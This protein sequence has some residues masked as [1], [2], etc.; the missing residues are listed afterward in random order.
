MR[1]PRTAA[2]GVGCLISMTAGGLSATLPLILGGRGNAAVYCELNDAFGSWMLQQRL[3]LPEDERKM[4]GAARGWRRHYQCQR[5][6]H[7]VVVT[8][9]AG[10]PGRIAAHSPEICYA[11]RDY[12]SMTTART[13][14]VD[15]VEGQFWI[16]SFRPRVAGQPTLTVAYA[17]H[18][19]R[20][21]RAPQ[22]PR[23]ELAGSAQLCRLQV[24]CQHPEWATGEAASAL[25]DFLHQSLADVPGQPARVP[26]SHP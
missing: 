10:P 21:W 22:S 23:W 15:G 1:P 20:S 19:G 5:T 2:L 6:Q 12:H 3:E 18:D 26:R 4:I 25:A 8:L 16:R 11:A 17:W 7:N 13:A 24:S 9:A 14:R